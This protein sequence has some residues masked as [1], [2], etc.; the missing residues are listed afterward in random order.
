MSAENPLEKFLAAVSASV[1]DDTFVRLILSTPQPGAKRPERILCRLV[2][3]RSQLHLSLTERF[4]TNDITRNLALDAASHPALVETI[5]AQ[6]RDIRPD[7]VVTF[8]PD[9]A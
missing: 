5:E 2:D 9:G 1:A 7:V 6:L 4:P 8:G 3:L